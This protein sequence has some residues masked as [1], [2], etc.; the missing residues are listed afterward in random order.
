M[1]RFYITFK[2]LFGLE[3]VIG[4]KRVFQ[5]VVRQL[6]YTVYISYFEVVSLIRLSVI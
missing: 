1:K 4:T 6:W 3:E 5:R 2:R